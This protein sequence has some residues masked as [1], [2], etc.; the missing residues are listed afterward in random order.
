MAI[1]KLQQSRA[2]SVIPSDNGGIY[3]PWAPV[4]TEATA[5]TTNASFIEATGVDFSN[6]EVGDIVVS[7][8]S[9]VTSV[10]TQVDTG[11]DRI[12]CLTAGFSGTQFSIFKPM[13]GLLYIGGTGNL[14]V[15]TDGGDEVTFSA[16][17]AGSFIPV[18]I[19]KVKATGTS[20]TDIL[21]LW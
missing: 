12:A 21:A 17:P 2:V 3:A 1:Q 18:H 10:I 14:A 7:A 8:G 5:T 13:S 11:N 4:I 20:A 15:V 16:L 19:R 6:V 9:G